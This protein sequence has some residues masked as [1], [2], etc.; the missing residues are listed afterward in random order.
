MKI[1]FLNHFKIQIK[2]KK[3]GH[4]RLKYSHQLC[5]LYIQDFIHHRQSFYSKIQKSFKFF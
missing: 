5:E 2:S 3:I 1:K 4:E